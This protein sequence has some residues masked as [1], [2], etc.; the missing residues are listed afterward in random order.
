MPSP[1]TLRS[2]RPSFLALAIAACL[3]LAA[4]MLAWLTHATVA[5]AVLFPGVL[6]CGILLESAHTYSFY[7]LAALVDILLYAA[8]AYAVLRLLRF[9]AGR[10]VPSTI[11][12]GQTK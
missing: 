2:Q 7:M 8:V 9:S 12:T 6:V 1:S 10:K 5:Q 4:G 11:N 3:V